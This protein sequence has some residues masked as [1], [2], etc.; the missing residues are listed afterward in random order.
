M[1]EFGVKRNEEYCNLAPELSSTIID[2]WDKNYFKV[3][4][5][6]YGESIEPYFACLSEKVPEKDTTA[7]KCFEDVMTYLEYSKDTWD[8]YM[9]VDNFEVDFD[10]VE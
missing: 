7:L 4:V 1:E 9:Y 2:Q 8:W 10:Q 6:D 5:I 3:Y